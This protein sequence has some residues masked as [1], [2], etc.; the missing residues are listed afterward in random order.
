MTTELIKISTDTAGRQAVSGRELHEFLGIET[1]YNDWFPRMV[2][3]GF[4]EKQDFEL[5]TQKRATN[6]P[7]ILGLKSP[8]MPFPSTWRRKSA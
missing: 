2:E 7:R 8:T 4:L 1:R 5:V 3:Y 6:N